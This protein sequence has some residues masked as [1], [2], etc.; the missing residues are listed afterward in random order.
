MAFNIFQAAKH[1][2]KIKCSIYHA[3]FTIKK[4]NSPYQGNE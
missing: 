1:E 4:P 2:P 3:S